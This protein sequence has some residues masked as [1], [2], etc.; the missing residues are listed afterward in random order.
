MLLA[1]VSGA[2][3]LSSLELDLPQSVQSTD[4]LQHLAFGTRGGL[5]EGG[6]EVLEQLQG[7]KGG[8][9]IS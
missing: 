9:T 7:S 4:L 1:K 3:E 5:F 6:D 8:G 2:Q